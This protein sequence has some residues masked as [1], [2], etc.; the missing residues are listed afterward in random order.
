MGPGFPLIWSRLRPV[1]IDSGRC[2]E[3]DHLK[4]AWGKLEE[5]EEVGS[6]LGKIERQKHNMFIM[7][8]IYHS[9]TNPPNLIPLHIQSVGQC[10]EHWSPWC[11]P[12]CSWWW[13][14]CAPGSD[15]GPAPMFCLGGKGWRRIFYVTSG[16][17][18]K[19]FR[20][21]LVREDCSRV[22]KYTLNIK[23]HQQNLP[24]KLS[25]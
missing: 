21:S 13:E 8:Y 22:E 19:S 11:S 12:A 10:L 14:C 25:L 17:G 15:P 1:G 3:D 5:L 6:Q 18:F 24:L 20:G 7:S 16:E 9:D 23:P 4:E 2:G